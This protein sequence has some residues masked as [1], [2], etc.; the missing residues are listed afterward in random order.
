MTVFFYLFEVEEESSEL[1]DSINNNRFTFKL[2]GEFS[3]L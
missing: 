3:T 2:I 1:L